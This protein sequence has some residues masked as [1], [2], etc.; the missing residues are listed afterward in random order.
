MIH[1]HNQ[2]HYHKVY[3]FTQFNN[4]ISNF[5]LEL[6]FDVEFGFPHLK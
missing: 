1:G 2:K 6:L 5:N 3:D 4:K